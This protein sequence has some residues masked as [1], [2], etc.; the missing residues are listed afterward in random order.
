[1]ASG[2]STPLFC[3]S[4]LS[5]KNLKSSHI[6]QEKFW[7]TARSDSS[8]LPFEGGLSK[9][10]SDVCWLPRQTS[11]GMGV[12]IAISN[13][14]LCGH[15]DKIDTDSSCSHSRY[16]HQ[17]SKQRKALAKAS[18]IFKSPTGSEKGRKLQTDTFQHQEPIS[19]LEPK[20]LH[21]HRYKYICTYI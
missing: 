5:T 7:G 8:I 12:T 11:R 4:N 21:T 9:T 2:A 19:A 3:A 16:R 18:L 17:V 1:M 15:S 14:A 20:R 13:E 10:L 6:P